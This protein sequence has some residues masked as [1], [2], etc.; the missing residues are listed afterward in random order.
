MNYPG[1]SSWVN[2]HVVAWNLGLSLIWVGFVGLQIGSLVLDDDGRIG[3][4]IAAI[5]AGSIAALGFAF[6]AAIL[7][8]KKRRD[9]A[10]V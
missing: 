10:A 6:T 8:V 3:A 9:R 2:T 4:N 7:A 5:V 1:V